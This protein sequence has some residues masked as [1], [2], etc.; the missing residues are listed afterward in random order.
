MDSASPFIER[1]RP[2]VSLLPARV[3]LC[4]PTQGMNSRAK[5]QL[6]DRANLLIGRISSPRVRDTPN[7]EVCAVTQLWLSARIHPLRWA[8]KSY[9]RREKTHGWSEALDEWTRGVHSSLTFVA[10]S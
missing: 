2:S 3:T 5:P 1:F 10:R 4:R 6:G 7:Q 8:A 9:A